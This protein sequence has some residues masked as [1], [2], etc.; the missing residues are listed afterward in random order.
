MSNCGNFSIPMYPNLDAHIK[1]Q[2]GANTADYLTLITFINDDIFKN[3]VANENID[4][5]KN[6]NKAYAALVRTT[7][8]RTRNSRYINM[9]TTSASLNGFLSIKAKNEGI[10]KIVGGI[11]GIAYGKM[12]KGES[13]TLNAA[14][15]TI[16]K[17]FGKQVQQIVNDIAKDN[18]NAKTDYEALNKIIN[19]SEE[20]KDFNSNINKFLARYAKLKNKIAENDRE[21]NKLARIANFIAKHGNAQQYNFFKTYVNFGNPIFLKEIKL[22]KDLIKFNNNDFGDYSQETLEDAISLD[23]IVN[24]ESS[25]DGDEVIDMMSKNWSHSIGE[26]TNWKDHMSTLCK[27]ILNSMPKLENSEFKQAV[28]KNGKTVYKYN[29]DRNNELGVINYDNG[30]FLAKML[31]TIPNVTSLDMFIRGIYNLATN[32]PKCASLIQLYNQLKDDKYLAM[33][34]MQTFNLPVVSKSEVTV[35]NVL[36]GEEDRLIFDARKTNNTSNFKE[37]TVNKIISNVKSAIM[38]R[39]FDEI[40]KAHEAWKADKS[41]KYKFRKILDGI[42]KD[43]SDTEFN[44]IL[45][46]RPKAVTQTEW[47]QILANSIS[48]II[49]GIENGTEIYN[50]YIKNRKNGAVAPESLIPKKTFEHIY[51]LAELFRDALN[52]NIQLTSRNSL[53]KQSS[54][55]IDRNYINVVVDIIQGKDINGNDTAISYAQQKFASNQYIYSNYLIS[56]PGTNFGLFKRIG[57]SFILNDYARDMFEI[58]LNS[59]IV[60]LDS[61]NGE[62]YNTMP[63]NDYI[64]LGLGYYLKELNRLGV[65]SKSVKDEKGNYRSVP[66]ANYIFPIPSDAPKNFTITAPKYAINDLYNGVIGDVNA[67][68]IESYIYK[69]MVNIAKQEVVNMVTARDLM[70]VA[71]NDGKIV[72]SDMLKNN[73]M[74]F[75][76]TYHYKGYNGNGTSS[77]KFYEIKNGYIVPT[78]EVFKFKRLADKNVTKDYFSDIIGIGK[79]IDILYGVSNNNQFSVRVENRELVLTEEAEQALE[80][81]VKNFLN[82][83]YNNASKNLKDNYPIV[84]ESVSEDIIKEFYINDFIVRDTMFDVFGGD[85]HFYKDYQSILKRI[86]HVQGSGKP[87]GNVDYSY[88]AFSETKTIIETPFTITYK[89]RDGSQGS[90]RV[91]VENTFNGITITNTVTKARDE[92][93]K[94]ITNLLERAN[95]SQETINTILKPYNTP[96]ATNDAQ[97]WITFEEWIR[98]ITAAGEYYKYKD[99]IDKLSNSSTPV[100]ELNA[101][102]LANFVQIQKNFYYDLYYDA[103]VQL[104]VPRQVKNAEF[105][106]IPKLIAGTELEEI[107][108]IMTRNNIHQLNTV[109]TTKVAKHNMLQL[110]DNEGNADL[111]KFEDDLQ[112]LIA[113]KGVDRFTYNHLYRQ[114]EVPQHMIDTKNKAGIQIMKKMLDNLDVLEDTEVK[115]VID[116]Y[117]ANIEENFLQVCAEL[118]IEVDSKGNIVLEDGNIKVAKEIF[119]ERFRE[120]AARQDASKAAL[121]FF[122]VDE[123]GELILPLFLSSMGNKLESISNSYFNANITKQLINGWHAAQLSDFGFKIL[124]EDK[125]KISTS[126]NLRYKVEEDGVVYSEIYLPRWTKELLGVNLHEW[127]AII[128]IKNPDAETKKKADA[129]KEVLTMIGYRIPTEGKQSI[130]TMRVVP[131]PGSE[132]GFLPTAYGSTVVVPYEFVHQTGSD[133]DVDSVYSMFKS[134]YVVNGIPKAHNINDYTPDVQ[135]YIRYLRGNVDKAGRKNLKNYFGKGDILNE[136]IEERKNGFTQKVTVAKE[137]QK[138]LEAIAKE[139]GLLSYNDYLKQSDAQRASKAARSNAIVDSFIKIL[140]H[141]EA[142]EENAMV[143]GFD[144]LDEANA[145]WSKLAGFSANKVGPSG[146]ST[147]LDWHDAAT[148]GIKLKGIS[149]NMDTLGSIGN[150]TRAYHSQGIKVVYST[151]VISLE[152]AKDRFMEVEELNDKRI[153]ITHKEL[154]WSKDNKNVEG[155]LITPYSSQ[156]TAHILDVMKK[157]SVHNENTYTFNAFKAITLMGSNF[158][159]AIGFMHQ[160]GLDT[161]VKIWK[162]G[163]SIVNNTRTNPIQAALRYY[164]EKLGIE[165]KD[166]HIPNNEL[167]A[168][169]DDL[170]EPDRDKPNPKAMQFLGTRRLTTAFLNG[171]CIFDRMIYK[172]RLEGKYDAKTNAFIDLCTVIQFNEL[173]DIGQDMSNNV[174]AVKADKYG[175]KATFFETEKIFRDIKECINTSNIKVGNVTMVESIFPGISENYNDFITADIEASTYKSLAYFLKYATATAIKVNQQIFETADKAFMDYV[176]SFAKYTNNGKLTFA[177]Y[178]AIKDYVVRSVITARGS[179]DFVNLPVVIR[180]GEMQLHERAVVNSGAAQ[181]Y[182]IQRLSGY[183]HGSINFTCNNIMDPSKEEIANYALLTPVEKITWLRENFNGLTYFDN[184][185]TNPYDERSNKKNKFFQF[186]TFKHEYNNI[187]EV[188]NAFEEAFTSNNPFIKLAAL[189]CVKYAYIIEGRFRPT[190]VRNSITNLP[191]H[192]VSTGGLGLGITARTNI[193][194]IAF[195]NDDAINFV[196]CN[197]NVFNL[198]N[199][200]HKSFK[201]EGITYRQHPVSKVYEITNN[202]VFRADSHPAF[203]RI[204][205]TVYAAINY[206]SSNGEQRLAYAPLNALEEFETQSG[207]DDSVFP[208]NNKFNNFRTHSWRTKSFKQAFDQLYAQI[209][210]NII[211]A[212]NKESMPLNKTKFVNNFDNINAAFTPLF[213]QGVINNQWYTHKHGELSN[214]NYIGITGQK[215]IIMS[216]DLQELR[217]KYEGADINDFAVIVNLPQQVIDKFSNVSLENITVPET[218][219][220]LSAA[221]DDMS[222]RYFGYK[223]I[224]NAHREIFVYIA[225]ESKTNDE[226]TQRIL[227]RMNANKIDIKS[228]QSISSNINYVNSVIDSYI[229]H[230]VTFINEDLHHFPLPDGTECDINDPRVYEAIK[231]NPLLESKFLNAVLRAI[232]FKDKYKLYQHLSVVNTD[233]KTKA[234]VETIRKTISEVDNNVTANEALYKWMLN[235]AGRY[236]TN[237]EIKKDLAAVFTTYGDTSSADLWIQDIH[238]NKDPMIQLVVKEFETRLELARLD[239]N[240]A[241][242]AFKDKI[243]KIKKDSAPRGGVSIND[244]VDSNGRIIRKYSE[245]WE[246]EKDTLKENEVIAKATYGENSVEHLKAKY[247]YEVFLGKTT[248]HKFKDIKVIDEVEMEEVTI[249]YER[250]R[251]AWDNMLLNSNGPVVAKLF[252]DYKKLVAEI[253][254]IYNNAPSNVLSEEDN[255]RIAEIMVK[256]DSITSPVYDNGEPKIGDAKIAAEL[257]NGYSARNKQRREWF[258]ESEVAPGFEEKLQANLEIIRRYETQRDVTGHLLIN[259]EELMKIP[260]YAEAKTWIRNNAKA[261]IKGVADDLPALLDITGDQHRKKSIST[262]SIKAHDARD[263]FGIVD[264]R[265]IPDEDIARIKEQTISMFKQHQ[266]NGNPY[267]G[268]LRSAP[269]PNIVLTKYFFQQLDSGKLFTEE[270][271]KI[272]EAINEILEKYWNYQTK[273]LQTWKITIEDLLGV[274]PGETDSSKKTKKG[275]IDLFK[276]YYSIKPDKSPRGEAVAKFIKDECNVTYNEEAFTYDMQQAK[277]TMGYAGFEAWKKVFVE[278]D[279]NGNEHPNRLIYGAILPKD[280]ENR[281]FVDLEVTDAKEALENKYIDV[282]TPYYWMKQRDIIK[283]NEAEGGVYSPGYKKWYLENH[284]WNPYQRRYVPLR[285]WTTKERNIDI[286]SDPNVKFEARTN[287]YI[288]SPKKEVLNPEYNKSGVAKYKLGTGYDNADYL[289]LNEYHHQL[290][291]EVENVLNKYV[292]TNSNQRYVDEG[293]LPGLAQ[294]KTVGFKE[295]PKEVLKFAGWWG[296]GADNL[297]YKSDDD[298][299]FEKDYDI[300]NQSLLQLGSSES[301]ELVPVPREKRED[302]TNEAYINRVKEALAH[303]REARKK[304]RAIHAERINRNWEEVLDSFIKTSNREY[305]IGVNKNLLYGLDNL[306]RNY[307]TFDTSGDDVKLDR[308]RSTEGESNYRTTKRKNSSLQV[309]EYTRRQVFQQFKDI[310]HS[311]LNVFGNLAQ[312]ITG[313]KYMMLNITGGI[314][315][316]LTGSANIFMERMAGEYV[317]LK[318]WELGKY[319]WLKGSISFMADLYNEKS[320]TLQDAIIKGAKVIDFDRLIELEAS[321]ASKY[322][323]RLRSLTFSPQTIGEH[324]MQGT[325]LFAMMKSHRVIEVNGEVKVLDYNLYVRE[326][327]SQAFNAMLTAHPEFKE[328]WEAFNKMIEDNP[329]LNVEYTTYRRNRFYDFASK[330]F[331]RELKKEYNKDRND[332]KDSM[333]KNF[334]EAPMLYDQFELVD[335]IAVIKLDSLLTNRMWAEFCNKVRMVNKKVHGVYDKIGAAKIESQWWGGMVMQYHKHLYPGFKKRYRWNPYYNE[336]LQSVEKGSYIS[337]IQFLGTPLTRHNGKPESFNQACRGIQNLIKDYANFLGNIIIE[338]DMLPEFEKANIRRNAAD[339]LYVVAAVV[340]AIAICGLGGDDEDDVLYNLALYQADRLASEAAAY[341]PWGMYG[342]AKKLWSSPIA[343]MQTMQD[344]FKTLDFGIELLLSDNFDEEYT[345]GRYKGL[346]KLEVLLIRNT[347]I[348]RNIDRIIQLPK[349]NSFYKLQENALGHVNYKAVAKDWFDN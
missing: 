147:Q 301:M 234:L 143:S 280:L 140:S 11:N 263:E 168:K 63:D 310:A 112:A 236:T 261:I 277:A 341:T 55:I 268:I 192:D 67:I 182:E 191:L 26:T 104:E 133:F 240:T 173:S 243:A 329:K 331:S 4:I 165:E 6:V 287:N 18:P 50:D 345:T 264:G 81:A 320:S 196:R 31:Y 72:E 100:E 155:H 259:R 169:I 24:S 327:E 174:N 42:I 73:P 127:Y 283:E 152:Q 178:N 227:N 69:Q 337:L 139:Y 244:I 23:E 342:E 260:E 256:I 34:F 159:T 92:A 94:S 121:D 90:R 303:N 52:V 86:K 80:N 293:Y 35:H 83:M 98:R 292:I 89:N 258:F 60:N 252:S 76:E 198:R 7:A 187:D 45:A 128:N 101:K 15:D 160:P 275:L 190:N 16:I 295:V 335:G 195:L 29:F 334:N 8:I 220:M 3:I 47:M 30:D 336:I 150:R 348:I 78:G 27:Y 314:A 282:E 32:N 309:R 68:N 113:N 291:D 343:F 265:K 156:T 97:S 19:D 136:V 296:K 135:G 307:D 95:C 324:Y 166:T 238:F 102:D 88:N 230:E 93:I 82:D 184:I 2:V 246:D 210:D 183:T 115:Q 289:K 163:N 167:L 186:L 91:K 129:I 322:V 226:Y 311:K 204:Y 209:G 332:I 349:N 203:I 61:F 308:K 114:Q 13:I 107:Y 340:G 215:A 111:E 44:N 171:G 245:A 46:N 33:A 56:R 328:E 64:A 285:I 232:T 108:N 272:G 99:L 248:V 323:N 70:F 146:F 290:I 218:K 39:S 110:W 325:M 59:G 58:T 131:F 149:V 79:P 338:F 269:I 199:Y 304:N 117:C 271:T 21:K 229:Q 126:A 208:F 85:P 214:Y 321:G 43:L 255:K 180:D 137:N 284:Y 339:L 193:K 123:H 278:A 14:I 75:Y 151:D 212:I 125:A 273:E 202:K 222:N 319:E 124:A 158:D 262:V 344:G 161:I 53:G 17:I 318:E 134:F 185:E 84:C 41:N 316:V 188:H 228:V 130:L 154:G 66:V 205:N 257:I 40:D 305:A 38:S 253:S 181:D 347:P 294:Q 87:F 250:D 172:N 122:N 201:R 270:Q 103:Q 346:N 298:V 267:A 239:G 237:E 312:N 254:Q 36:V 251:L 28:D 71:T 48:G 105:V 317:N 330:Y 164:A 224:A 225:D 170:F 194:N 12:L 326:C 233:D 37:A 235:F 274:P 62:V 20:N 276:S 118:G 213:K 176:Y 25:E 109:E 177:Q 49:T 54:D 279:E 221:H 141:P 148:S 9:D 145:E 57:N 1:N 162:D 281:L 179:N 157:G 286:T 223:G 306:L 297:V 315:N 51:R 77:P 333:R 249:N 299:T 175:A 96:A 197:P 189:D 120:N 288:H 119:L 132:D 211:A 266:A 116:C 200:T 74:Q 313:S 247:D 138:D 241:A 10:K 300:P 217:K 219:L 144:T 153:L 106:L 231:D 22:N 302:E 207:I 142:F 216:S 242:K 65:T 5:D 206:M